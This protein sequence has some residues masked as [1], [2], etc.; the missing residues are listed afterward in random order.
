MAAF[1]KHFQNKFRVRVAFVLVLG[2]LLLCLTNGRPFCLAD[3]TLH[4]GQLWTPVTLEVPI[5]ERLRVGMEVQPRWVNDFQEISVL[6]VRPSVTFDLK[7]N[8]SVTAGYF[9]SPNFPLD[10]QPE[11][12]PTTYEHRSWQQSVVSH[13]VF[14]GKLAERLNTRMAHR[15]RL[16]QR[17]L[18]NVGDVAFRARYQAMLVQPIKKSPWS[19]VL[20]DEVFYNFNDAGSNIPSGLAANRLFT[21]VRRQ[22]GKSV[23]VEGGYM[24]LWQEGFRQNPSQVNHIIVLRANMITPQLIKHKNQNQPGANPPPDIP[25]DTPENLHVPY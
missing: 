5:V 18:P 15:V 14:K 23:Q 17:F 19:L 8:W 7:K 1:M 16:E 22:F 13:P 3:E 2:P 21:G 9:W 24:L 11:N 25:N 12:T 4:D 10:T 20:S 6:R